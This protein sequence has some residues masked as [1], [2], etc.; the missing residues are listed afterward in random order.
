MADRY[1]LIGN[2]VAHSFSPRIHTLFAKQTGEDVSYE[3]IPAPRAGFVD[4]VTAFV[5]NGGRGANVT[6]P[7]KGEAFEFAD[8]LGAHAEISGAVNTLVF[9]SDGVVY[10]DNTD[11]AGLLDDLRGQGCGIE[12]AVVLVVGAGGACRG[13][14]PALLQASIAE[15]VIVNRTHSR[16]VRLADYFS[17][18]G[19]VTARHVSDVGEQDFDGVINATSASLDKQI[20]ELPD[21][22]ARTLNWG[23]DLAYAREPTPFVTWLQKRGVTAAFD[24]V[25]MLVCQA[26][27]SFE[28]WRGI[29]PD[30]NAIRLDDFR[31]SY[32]S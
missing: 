24:G 25:G 2:P 7:F 31:R 21:S 23:Y 4:T 11:G 6:L 17:R 32:M 10:G 12:S 22:L 28:I 9:R 3:L 16:A 1:G 5:E 20:P 30:V 14:V 15:L 19:P 27:R 8:E 26:A 18:F 13:I 29:R